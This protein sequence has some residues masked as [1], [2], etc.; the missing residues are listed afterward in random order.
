MAL[1]ERDDLRRV[2]ELVDHDPG[3]LV[4]EPVEIEKK[5][6][7]HVLQVRP[8]REIRSAVVRRHAEHLPRIVEQDGDRAEGQK[9]RPRGRPAV[10]A[11]PLMHHDLEANR[12]G[13]PDHELHRQV[14][15]RARSGILLAESL[16]EGPPVPGQDRPGAAV[17]HRRGVA[18]HQQP[19]GARPQRV[20]HRGR[21]VEVE[22]TVPAPEVAQGAERGRWRLRS[23]GRLL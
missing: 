7:P 20:G 14:P 12:P 21:V 17:A 8:A 23:D 9:P 16:Q 19:D 4:C 13:E 11:Y 10:H 1:Q 18:A 6:A 22:R 3:Q 15:D 2:P 5:I